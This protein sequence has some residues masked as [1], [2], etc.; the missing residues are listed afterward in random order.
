MSMFAKVKFS[1]GRV[2]GGESLTIS[3]LLDFGAV[4]LNMSG[5]IKPRPAIAYELRA[6]ITA[7]EFLAIT[8]K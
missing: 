3:P 8:R 6:C 2:C 4:C 5:A 7:C 1:G